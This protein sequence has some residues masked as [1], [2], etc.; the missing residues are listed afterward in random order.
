MGL[1]NSD[2]A[3]GTLTFWELPLKLQLIACFCFLSLSSFG[4]LKILPFL[5]GKVADNKGEKN[6]QKILSYVTDNPGCAEYDLLKNLGMKRGTF[7]YH[8]GKLELSNML[9]LFRQGR[10]ISYFR[11]TPSVENNGFSLYS[12][13]KNETRK[14]VFETIIEK[15]GVTGKELSAKLGVDKST[16]HWHINKLKEENAI[17]CEKHG[18]FKR[19]YPK[20]NF[21]AI[22]GNKIPVFPE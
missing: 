1:V 3:D 11:N 21:T 14:N 7:R 20:S 22:R 6:K 15:P 4:F 2:G 19:Y 8:S 13:S 5:L 18:R 9:V 17:C 12:Y 16:I 10:F